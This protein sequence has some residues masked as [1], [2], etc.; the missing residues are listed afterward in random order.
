MVNNDYNITLLNINQSEQMYLDTPECAK[1]LVSCQSNATTCLEAFIYC[2]THL[3]LPFVAS[4]R[5]PYDIRR[6]CTEQIPTQCYDFSHI[7]EYL[8][9]DVVKNY[10][11]VD[12]KHVR[13][14][15]QCS[16]QVNMQFSLAGDPLRSVTPFVSDLLE[17]N[18]RVLIYAGDADLMCNWY[19]NQAWT[20]AL[21]WSGKG[22]FNAAHQ[23]PFI[24]Y[25]SLKNETIDAGLAKSNGKLT[26][27]RV[28]N[29]GHMVPM[30]QPAVA[31]DMI[32]K[33]LANAEF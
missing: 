30:D 28:Y 14:W 9:L 22:T 16:M 15:E 21:E 13:V 19:G 6:P 18:V 3:M 26:F 24:A 7:T 32:N 25:D 2:G 17:N 11:H 1:L 5:N 20:N 10:L 23:H 8:N 12:E 29:S 27:L 33:F 31:L 4:G